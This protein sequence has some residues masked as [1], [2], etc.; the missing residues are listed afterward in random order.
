AQP[1][2]MAVPRTSRRYFRGRTESRE[3]DRQENS[4]SAVRDDQRTID[5]RADGAVVDKL[6]RSKA[7][8]Q[9]P[10]GCRQGADE[11]IPGEDPRAL[12][13]AH[14]LRKCGLLDR[15][16]WADFLVARAEY[17]NRR[18]RKQPEVI[19]SRRKHATDERHEHRAE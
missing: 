18:D 10:Q 12:F 15:Q 3:R 2:G 8:A 14:R 5:G 1:C 13:A 11:V 4:D 17:A 16:K 19:L 6:L 9:G 7:A